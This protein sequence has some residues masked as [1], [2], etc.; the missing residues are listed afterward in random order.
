MAANLGFLSSASLWEQQIYEALYTSIKC[1]EENYL[2][3]TVELRGLH[4]YCSF[5]IG[6]NYMY[7]TVDFSDLP[8][9]CR[10]EISLCRT[11]QN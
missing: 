10:P 7:T 2:N 9:Y 3:A 4:I 5:H 6:Q 11:P 1:L 8:S